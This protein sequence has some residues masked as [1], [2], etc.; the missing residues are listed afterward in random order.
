MKEDLEPATQGDTIGDLQDVDET[1]GYLDCAVDVSVEAGVLLCGFFRQRIAADPKGIGDLVTEAD[2]SA[3][4]MIVSRLMEMFPDHGFVGEEGGRSGR[5]DGGLCWVIDP[6]DGTL[7]FWHHFP[8]FAVSIALLQDGDPVVGV[9]YHPNAADGRSDGDGNLYTAI[10]GRGAWHNGVAVHVSDHDLSP[11]SLVA[12]STSAIAEGYAGRILPHSAR[13]R[14]TGSAA[15]NLCNVAT[16]VFEAHIDTGT[17]VWDIAAGGLILREAGGCLTSP[18][19][20]SVFPLACD[21]L[22]RSAERMP[23][24]GTNGRVH[25]R[26]LD[27][28]AGLSTNHRDSTL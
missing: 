2:R 15:I 6:L 9:V 27:L 7:N 28:V 22:D 4:R 8:M 18:S 20:P 12:L 11:V 19:G 3:E 10:R 25:E 17:K 24:V 23:M 5:A 26:L 13:A 21:A 16:G 1:Q 14:D